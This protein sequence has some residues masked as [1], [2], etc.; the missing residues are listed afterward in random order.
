MRQ[1]RGPRNSLDDIRDLSHG[2]LG[3]EIARNSGRILRR[4]DGADDG[5]AIQALLRGA[6][7]R[8]DRL[9]VGCVDAADADGWHGAVAGGGEE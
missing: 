9:G 3:E 8:E 5:D 1:R 4:H 2:D 7:L 6:A